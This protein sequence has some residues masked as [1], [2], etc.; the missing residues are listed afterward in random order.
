MPTTL[1]PP[2]NGESSSLVAD[3]GDPIGA[4]I[5]PLPRTEGDWPLRA[6]D[7]ESG[8][9]TGCRSRTMS[10]LGDSVAHAS[11]R[12][13]VRLGRIRTR[14]STRDGGAIVHAGSTVLLASERCR[15]DHAIPRRAGNPASRGEIASGYQRRHGRRPGSEGR[16]RVPATGLAGEQSALRPPALQFWCRVG[17]IVPD[18]HGDPSRRWQRRGGSRRG[19][20]LASGAPRVVLSIRTVRDRQ[21]FTRRPHV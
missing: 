1:K 18:T 7:P 14:Q 8:R 10:S 11:E 17:G 6:A 4:Y 9:R 21:G 5:S 19:R 13:R 15:Q 20:A 16:H 12:L 2:R 3:A